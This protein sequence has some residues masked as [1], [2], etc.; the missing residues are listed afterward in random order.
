[1]KL[2][3]IVDSTNYKTVKEV[4]KAH[5]HISDRLILKIK[6]NNSILLNNNPAFLY[7]EINLNDKILVDIS[8]ESKSE[9]I[10]PVKMNLKIVFEDD[11]M[12]IINKPADIPVHPSMLHFTNSISNGV[13]Y[14]FEKNNI[15]SKIHP[16]NRLDKNT[17]GLVVFAK[18]QYIQSILSSQM[19]NKTFKKS[20]LAILYGK[21]DKTS[22]TIDQPISRKKD[23]IIEREINKAGKKA[24][25]HYKL[26]K[27]Y[28]NF[29]LV[30]FKLE[31]G[32]THQIR[33]HSKYIGHPILGDTL[34]GKT[35]NL[36]NRQALHAYKIEFV[37]P[38]TN[39]KILIKTDLPNDMASILT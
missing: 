35:S 19:T 37:H 39:K 8:F 34:Y 29:C 31:T 32:R 26:I 13:Q 36:I 3:Y 9:N 38:I 6:Q 24:I 21:L 11:S 7:S 23:S 10:I 5:F 28:D 16:V 30:E 15:Q 25:T 22:G 14:Y 20:Y 17:S 1:M 2:E 27:N 33:V 12:L 18:N 4:L